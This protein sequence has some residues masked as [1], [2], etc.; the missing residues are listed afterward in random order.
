MKIKK[1][2]LI[3][4]IKEELN[5]I[6]ESLTEKAKSKAQQRFMGMVR[7]VQKGELGGDEVSPEVGNLAKSMNPSDVEDFASTSLKGLPDKVKEDYGDLSEAVE[8]IGEGKYKWY[9]VGTPEEKKAVDAYLRSM[10]TLGDSTS[11]RL[12]EGIVNEI[13]NLFKESLK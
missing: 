2:K 5:N 7:A 8:Y 6:N 3:N 1:T 9:Y 10:G 11:D 12:S 4:I 13:F